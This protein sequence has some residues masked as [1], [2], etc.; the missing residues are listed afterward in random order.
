LNGDDVAAGGDEARG[1]EVP[2]AVER[3][4]GTGSRITILQIGAI[5]VYEVTVLRRVLEVR[6][7]AWAAVNR[8]EE[9]LARL[10]DVVQMQETPEAD[11]DDLFSF[12]SAAGHASGNRLLGAFIASVH[13]STEPTQWLEVT[14]EVSGDIVKQHAEIIRRIEFPSA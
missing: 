12:H 11:D 13:A 5:D 2:Q 6:A 4:S 8:T 7:A 1:K 10:N 9:D 3:D 14:P